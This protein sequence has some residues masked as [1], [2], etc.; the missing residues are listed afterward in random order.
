[1][2]KPFTTPTDKEF[3]KG[4]VVDVSRVGWTNHNWSPH[5]FAY[6]IWFDENDIGHSP[7]L[8]T[9]TVAGEKVTVTELKKGV[10]KDHIEYVPNVRADGVAVVERKKKK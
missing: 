7:V 6:A 3:K 8:V 1:M 2:S 4:P 5:N 9:K 10:L